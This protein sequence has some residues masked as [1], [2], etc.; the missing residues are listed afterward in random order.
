MLIIGS[1]IHGVKIKTMNWKFELCTLLLSSFSPFS[2]LSS[3]YSP[4]MY[5]NR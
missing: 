4:R 5:R 3:C 1:I 2:S